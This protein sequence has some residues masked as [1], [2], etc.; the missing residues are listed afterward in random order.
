MSKELETLERFEEAVRDHTT[1]GG[2]H[3]DDIP[4]IKEEYADAKADLMILL[5]D[6]KDN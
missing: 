1:M 5:I 2:G 3:P 4:S 6:K